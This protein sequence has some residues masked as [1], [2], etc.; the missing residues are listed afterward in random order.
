MNAGSHRVQTEGGRGGAA[1]T[2]GEPWS[3]T[4]V[5]TSAEEGTS[6]GPQVG[7]DLAVL[8]STSVIMPSMSCLFM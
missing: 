3:P 5:Q 8:R 1:G 7:T 2:Y 6:R 4:S